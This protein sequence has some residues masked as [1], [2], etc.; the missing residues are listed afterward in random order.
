VTSILKSASDILGASLGSFVYHL[1]MLLAVEAAL[2][3]AWSEWRRAH[4][5]Q[6]R[7]LLLAM[8]GLVGARLIYIV[9]ALL[10]L[11]GQVPSTILLPLEHTVDIASICLLGLGVAQTGKSAPSGQTGA[12]IWAWLLG[13][14]LVAAV[15]VGGTFMFLWSKAETGNPG[16]AY[17]QSWQALVW[18]VWQMALAALV[19]LASLRNTHAITAKPARSLSQP[20]LTAPMLILFLGGLLPILA[21]ATGSAT[22]SL[23]WG[24]LS[25]LVAYPLI[26][27]AVY[28]ST[29]AN[30]RLYAEQSKEISEASLDQIKSLLLLFEGARQVSSSLSLPEVLENSVRAV[31]RALDADQCAIALPEEADPGYMRLAAVYNVLAGKSVPR[32]G[33]AATFPLEYQLTIQQVMRRKKPVLIDDP[34][35]VQLR[36]LF[37][38]LGSSDAGPLMV[39]PLLLDGEAMGAVLVGNSRCRRSFTPN[40]AK[41]CQSMAEHILV[42]IQ[43]A[44]R[45]QAAQ[46]RIREL[47]RALA[48][49]LRG[50]AGDSLGLSSQPTRTGTSPQQRDRAWDLVDPVL[51]TPPEVEE[52]GPTGPARS[53]G[54]GQGLT[55]S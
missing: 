5:E 3:M 33:E 9:V 52:A 51:D 12:R 43:N 41:L 13:A 47:H 16:L 55:G 29:V 6:S 45:Y 4:D 36:V 24:R 1:L 14:N 46:D 27:A 28:Q 10:S 11:A 21:T 19:G 30:M 50:S 42:A 17:A 54:S 7:R 44:R 32:R 38:L 35:N 15:A 18:Y 40:E 25:N 23:A 39:Q 2:A 49:Q 37:N 31:A 34:D 26:V 20:S 22:G 53:L 8:A 48:D